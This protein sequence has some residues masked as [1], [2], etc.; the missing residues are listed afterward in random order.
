MRK[1]NFTTKK[2]L[3]VFLLSS[4]ALI[5]EG[6]FLY[7][8]FQTYEHPNAKINELS[9]SNN[10]FR[11]YYSLTDRENTTKLY[12]TKLYSQLI[13]GQEKKLLYQHYAFHHQ[14][15]KTSRKILLL[16]RDKVLL[17]N[18]YGSL[19]KELFTVPNKK[20]IGGWRVSL[21]EKWVFF[22]VDDDDFKPESLVYALNIVTGD[23]KT[24]T[25]DVSPEYTNRNEVVNSKGMIAKINRGSLL[26]GDKEIIR[27]PN[28]D[29][30]LNPGCSY[31][32]WLPFD[33][34]LTVTC[35]G[36]LRI[37]DVNTGKHAELD[38]G[39]KID[40]FD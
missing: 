38:K 9:V 34:L 20:H 13:T 8:S 4:I 7:N 29:Y 25:S 5:A 23:Y 2:F 33:N 32:K 1:F 40:W 19:N 24:S 31:L 10:S 3:L 26:V 18:E 27:W 22:A 6:M 16:Q 35:A 36:S 15:L 39:Y 14:L 30:K 37:V 28:Y 21:D 17:L 12:I 11:V